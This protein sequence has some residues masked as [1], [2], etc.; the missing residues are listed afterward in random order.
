M[1]RDP[2]RSR[3]IRVDEPTSIGELMPDV[4]RKIWDRGRAHREATWTP[5]EIAEAEILLRER[6]T[7]TRTP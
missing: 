6:P 4:L 3:R 5:E 1:R 2:V 7:P